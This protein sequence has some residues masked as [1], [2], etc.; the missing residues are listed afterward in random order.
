MGSDI[1]STEGLRTQQQQT[2][3]WGRPPS[4]W[5]RRF[6][7][8]L[9]ILF[10]WRLVYIAITPLDLV[11]DEAYY[12]DWSRKLAWGYYSK[13]PLIAWVNALSTAL[14]GTSPITVRLPAV[15]LGS[16]SLVGLY[17]LAA[18]LFD[19]RVAFWSV[20]A[21][22]ASP[23]STGFAF[24]MTIDTLLLCSW[25]LALYTLWRALDDPKNNRRWWLLS[26]LAIALGLL[27]K[28]MM[29]VFLLLAAVHLALSREHRKWLVSP[30][31]YVTALLALLAL[32]P[33][34]WWNM[35]HNWITI[36]HTAHNVGISSQP[37]EPYEFIL[38]FLNFV[39]TQL[40]LISPL[41]WSLLAVVG[42]PL[43]ARLHRIDN[44]TRFLVLF[45]IVP[46]VL[47]ALA[48]FAKKINANWPAAFYPAGM[49]LLAAWAH[50]ALCTRAPFARW[51]RL[52]VP[53]VFVGTMLVVITYA[54]TF[55][56]QNASLGGGKLDPTRRLKGW[57]TLAESIAR[58]RRDAPRPNNTF[59]LASGRQYVSEL[60]FY[61]PDR[62]RVYRWNEQK[63]VV[64]T[65]YELWPG[66]Q[67][68][69]G[70]DALVI[71]EP[72]QPLPPDLAQAFTKVT[73]IGK[74]VAPIGPAASRQLVIYLG[75]TLKHW[76]R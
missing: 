49:L 27:S 28:Q 33:P 21:M 48:S 26:A 13:P 39:G 32:T 4:Q 57:Q 62:P 52:F 76:P 37:R 44:A 46:L 58:V 7:W 61:L 71:L 17:Y 56:L 6:W 1:S 10:C 67:D 65:Q 25:T 29:L 12:W 59:L 30:L 5:H 20:A 54:L 23:M 2:R 72:A 55:F 60:A 31:P 22:A 42:V 34:L 74:V 15:F 51:R 24:L 40:F 73:F 41:T 53:G 14:F 63:G 69:A 8:L 18:R 47:F 43:L 75:H 36:Q 66:P 38:T 19:D 3:G 68:K 70:W 16:V 11:P 64:K 9:L 35:N 50:G 45:S